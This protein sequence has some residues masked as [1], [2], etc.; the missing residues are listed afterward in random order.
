MD[1]RGYAKELRESATKFKLSGLSAVA[2]EYRQAAS[3]I[4]ELVKR[5]DIQKEIILE[6]MNVIAGIESYLHELERSRLGGKDG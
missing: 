3:V 5:N 2:E 1:Y 4:E 6:K